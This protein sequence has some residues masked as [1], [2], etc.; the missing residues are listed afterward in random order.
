MIPVSL[1][2]GNY[3]VLMAVSLACLSTLLT[4]LA[5]LATSR[6]ARLWLGDH[7]RGGTL[8]MALLAVVGGIFPYQQLSQWLVAQREARL[9]ASLNLVL[10][11]PTRLAGLDMPAGTA[12][13]L[14][15]PG[16]PASFDRATFPEGQP[17][18]VQGVSATRLFHYPATS[19]QPETLSVEIARDQALDGWLCAHGH[20][21]EFVLLGGQPRFASCHLAIGNTLSQLNINMRQLVDNALADVSSH[22]FAQFKAKGTDNM[23]LLNRGLA[24]PE[25]ARMRIIFAK[26]WASLTDFC[27]FNT[28]RIRLK[29]AALRAR[30]GFTRP[31]IVD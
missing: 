30:W 2:G 13:R 11:Q 15:T 7:R 27:P 3:Y 26:R 18:T 20:R 9:G 23:L 28:F 10:A 6:G 29:T 1:P 24:V 14:A 17:V 12:L 4:W 22:D 19:R 25:Q 8:L 5:I 21:L 31:V 16:E